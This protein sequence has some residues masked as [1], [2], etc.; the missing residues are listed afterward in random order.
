[1]KETPDT[2]AGRLRDNTGVLF[3]ECLNGFQA[4]SEMAEL[5]EDMRILSLNAELAAGRAGERG[6]AVRAL[7]QYTREL[8]IRLNAI[9]ANMLNLKSRTYGASAMVLRFL[10]QLH[11]IDLA[12]LLLRRRE[13]NDDN[14]SSAI[15]IVCEC[16]QSQLAILLGDVEEMVSAVN[17][18]ST[19]AET[20]AEV[21]SQAGSIATNIA[22]E[23]AAAGTHEAEFKQVAV[24]MGVYVEQLRNMVDN[25]A[26]SIRDAVIRGR[27][28]MD[29]ARENIAQA[30]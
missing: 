18:L 14:G 19:E 13:S 7:T 23:A 5:A 8:V 11:Y 21:M 2:V 27:T 10:H 16:R 6:A 17:G 9:E 28:L 1:M 25:A 30:R 4:F 3:S 29:Q 12:L 22:I 20:V 24:T 15:Q 26:G